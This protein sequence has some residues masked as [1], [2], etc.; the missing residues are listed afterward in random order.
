MTGG[1][2]DEDN[3]GVE[4]EVTHYCGNVLSVSG[5]HSPDMLDVAGL[6]DSVTIN[7]DGM[8]IEETMRRHFAK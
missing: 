6:C 2:I 1:A 7:S 3:N 5:T 4:V 8:S